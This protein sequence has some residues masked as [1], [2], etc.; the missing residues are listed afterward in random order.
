MAN[1]EYDKFIMLQ[2]L[3]LCHYMEPLVGDPRTNVST[4]ILNRM[5]AELPTYDEYHLVYALQL[6]ADH[7]PEVFIQH[8]PKYLASKHGSVFCMAFNILDRLADKYITQDLI[9]SAHGVA[10]S[11]RVENMVAKMLVRLEDRLR[12]SIEDGNGRVA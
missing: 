12:R 5:L 2:G 10:L 8:V 4:H 3:D 9:D 11:R 6:G 1:V 7:L